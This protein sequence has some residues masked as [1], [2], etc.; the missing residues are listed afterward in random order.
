MKKGEKFVVEGKNIDVAIAERR[1]YEFLVKEQE[2]KQWI[3]DMIDEK[4]PGATSELVSKCRDGI[5]FCRLA[6]IFSV[7]P[8]KKIHSVTQGTVLQM[9]AIENVTNFFK[10][11]SS[12][13]F[14][15][16]NFFSFTDIWELKNIVKVVVCIHAL[17]NY[18]EKTFPGKYKKI[19]DF[20]KLGLK[21][22]EDEIQRTKKELDK[23]DQQALKL[24]LPDAPEED[25]KS[26]EIELEL[27]S[28][29]ECTVEGEGTK[30]AY[31]GEKNT[32]TIFAKDNLGNQLE[33]GDETFS[34]VLFKKGDKSTKV[35]GEVIDLKN[36][37]YTVN[38]TPTKSGEYEMEVYL[39]DI[40]SDEDVTNIEDKLT[41]IKG[42]PFN[43]QVFASKKSD[44]S[45]CKIE[46]TG[47][48]KATAGTE[49][50]FIIS[51]FDTF[52][53]QGLG[54]EKFNVSLYCKENNTKVDAKVTSLTDGKYEVSYV[55]PKTGSYELAISLGD[56][57]VPVT[58]KVVVK[59]IGISKPELCE[60]NLDTK[61]LKAGEE[62]KFVIL[63]VD[64]NGNMR[65]SGGEKFTAKLVS[66]DKKTTITISLNDLQ[67]GHYEGQQK[68]V[69]KGEYQLE[70]TL[71]GKKIK[72]S[73]ISLTVKESEKIDPTKSKV[74]SPDLKE[75]KAGEKQTIIIQSCD[76]YGNPLSKGG[77][78]FISRITSKSKKEIY[79]DR[80][81]VKDLGNG[82]YEITFLL[83]EKGEYILE[84]LHNKDDKTTYVN[85]FPNEDIEVIESGIT[86]PYKCKFDGEGFNEATAK[87]PTEF[88][89]I[90]Y[91]R[92]GN[93]RSTG[94]DKIQVFF[95][96]KEKNLKITPEITDCED[97]TYA[98]HYIP[99]FNTSGEV[100]L[101]SEVWIN[102]V[103]ICKENPTTLKVKGIKI[104][105]INE[106]EINEIQDHDL[107]NSLVTL[108]KEE[109][110]ENYIGKIQEL[111]EKMIVQIRS[112]FELE[113]MVKGIEKNIELLIDN[114]IKVEEAT[115]NVGLFGKPKKPK[116]EKDEKKKNLTN[117]E[118]YSHLFY[119]LQT[120][121]KYLSKCLFIVAPEM[122]DSLLETVI[123]S[124][125]GY[126]FSPREEYLILSLFKQTLQIEVDRET[127]GVGSFLKNNPVLP[128][129]IIT[130]ARRIQGVQF[131][132]KVLYDKILDPIVSMK[133][134]DLDINAVALYKSYIS[135]KEVQTGEK[136]NIDQK[137]ITFEVAMKED[138]ISKEIYSRIEKLKQICDGVLQ[139][140]CESA[141]ELPYGM[142]YICKELE[143]C[144][145]KK[146]PNSNPT[147]RKTVITYLIHYRFMSPAIASPDGFGLTSK[148]LSQL[149][150]KNLTV[151]TKVFSSL[152]NRTIFDS[153]L[154]PSMCLMND[155]LR[156]NEPNYSDFI[157]KLIDVPEPEDS[158]GVTEFLELT[159]KSLPSIT[160]KMN[161][162]YMTHKLLLEKLQF[163][164]QEKNDPLLQILKRQGMD[165]SPELLP[166]EQNEEL[167]LP[168][169]NG[170][171]EKSQPNKV[172]P[173]Q[174]YEQTKDNFRKVLKSLPP[175]CIGDNIEFTLKSAKEYAQK[176]LSE[177]KNDESAKFLLLYVSQV[178]GSL[179]LLIEHKKITKENNFKEIIIDIT[180][181]IQNTKIVLEKQKKEYERLEAS[182]QQLQEHH[183][184]LKE[185]GTDFDNFLKA[186]VKNETSTTV[187]KKKHNF[188]YSQLEKKGVIKEL[189]VMKSQR[190][191]VKFTIYM[192]A[193]GVF[194][195]D[196][197][198][199][200]VVVKTIPIQLEELLQKKSKGI[201]NLDY[202][203]VKLDVNMTLHVMNK[204]FVV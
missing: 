35:V 111:R 163:I 106:E 91:D 124:I 189:N 78:N 5:Y 76:S 20:S 110:T 40:L 184:F 153:K 19:K 26:E 172:S 75:V 169:I 108:F 122:I 145:K 71:G 50:K 85:G 86:D 89:I 14:P 47:A 28:P 49:S 139:G 7:K 128:K 150:R 165:V 134:L 199:G 143:N 13:K 41:L 57:K 52:G 154:D 65:E 36:G 191:Q 34:V 92:Y 81:T 12:V 54:G 120:N 151:I 70:V 87:R 141:N 164:T 178:E 32:F 84:V 58:E 31:V 162:I 16:Y 193:P 132:K 21:F 187:S 197:K 155:W 25:E 127:N 109:T 117:I 116:E 39:V 131:L 146:H 142:R 56:N 167:K 194:N 73:P 6:N 123:L 181:E 126:A 74:I 101:T 140:I 152:T 180:K 30:K 138:F 63:A 68:I 200:G 1:A 44:A 77:E 173:E 119:L 2:A 147:E 202:E 3:E 188:T 29:D 93:M 157:D 97:G 42:C 61:E 15:E 174:V 18:L 83:E 175:E 8:I 104:K 17:A 198:V 195:V 38:Y 67:N 204:L 37:K 125:Y 55:C 90:T 24:I 158:L 66:Q 137:N 72:N 179:N 98:V 168:L 118:N 105:D 115:K 62:L 185:K 190:N 79:E 170:F 46:G 59:D 4:I 22:N 133:G 161:E 136:M 203:Y 112:N 177:N 100:L 51:S 113:N 82:T 176:K 10:S 43:V 144:L 156:Q 95:Y 130:Y 9:L 159:Q 201:E 114:R 94:N 99:D 135:D 160:I 186:S 23:L 103:D 48:T 45:K 149:T 121:P 192:S 171:S 166:N 183:N 64:E 88:N 196:A 80:S 60:I 129:M 102:G 33:Q 27:A 182:Y 11:C 148:T 53:N 107:L 96:N 69:Q